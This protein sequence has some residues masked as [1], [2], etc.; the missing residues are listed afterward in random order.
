MPKKS[1]HAIIFMDRGNLRLHG[2]AGD[3][4]WGSSLLDS[5]K[6]QGQLTCA[7]ISDVL[8]YNC[9]TIPH[10]EMVLGSQASPQSKY[11]NKKRRYILVEF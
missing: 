6:L 10:L 4:C 9:L 7:D 3:Y 8:Q 2:R 11:T 5:Q 1:K